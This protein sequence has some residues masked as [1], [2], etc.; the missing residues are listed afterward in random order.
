MSNATQAPR[1][2]ITDVSGKAW[3]SDPDVDGE[4]AKP[5]AYEA[6]TRM[7]GDWSELNSLTLQ[8]DGRALFFNPANIIAVTISNPPDQADR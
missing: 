2:E 6:F 1:I 8:V 4:L 5:G 3:V 7:F